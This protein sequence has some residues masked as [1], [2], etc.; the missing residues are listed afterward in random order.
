MKEE[1]KEG[2]CP[3]C[4]NELEREEIK[5]DKKKRLKEGSKHLEGKELH[6]LVCHECGHVSYS[7]KG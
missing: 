3:I 6:K 2:T 4:G 7:F 1:I 5:K